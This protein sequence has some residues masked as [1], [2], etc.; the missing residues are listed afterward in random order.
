MLL[1]VPIALFTLPLSVDRGQAGV[2]SQLLYLLNYLT[3][4]NEKYRSL[5]VDKMTIRNYSEWI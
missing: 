3:F 5:K 2:E 1:V 4:S